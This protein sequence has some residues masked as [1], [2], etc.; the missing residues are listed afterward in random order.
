[1]MVRG[2]KVHWQEHFSDIVEMTGMNN[3]WLIVV[4]LS[5]F[6]PDTFLNPPG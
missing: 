3:S 6:A 2:L 5:P 4:T 1:M